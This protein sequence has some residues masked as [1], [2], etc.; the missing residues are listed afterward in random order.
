MEELLKEIEYEVG[1]DKKKLTLVIDISG[2]GVISGS[3][4]SKVIASTRGNIIIP[5]TDGL[6]MGLNIYRSI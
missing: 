2:P 3:G 1:Q 6:K 4:K 5:G